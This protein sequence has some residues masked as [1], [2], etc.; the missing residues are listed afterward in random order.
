[1]SGETNEILQRLARVETKL[2]MM[3]ED[4]DVAAEALKTA[5]EAMQSARSAHHRLNTHEK[6]IYWAGTTIIGA[7][8]VGII[9]FFM[10]G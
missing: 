8:V 2:D 5:N 6:I 1:M 3:L 9:S 10:K 7:V 4:R